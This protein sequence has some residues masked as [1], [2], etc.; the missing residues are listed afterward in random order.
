MTSSAG[1]VTTRYAESL[2]GDL[3]ASITTD[4]A[5]TL[6]LATLHGD[7]VTTIDILPTAAATDPA[8]GITGWSDYT[9]YGAPRDP[10]ATDVVD[11]DTGYGWLGAKQRS[12]TTD[13]AGLTLMGDRLYN[14]VTGR[15]TS[16][17]PEPGGNPN[18]YTYPGDPINMYDLDGHF[19]WGWVKTAVQWGLGNSRGARIFRSACGWTPGWLG[20]ACGGYL[21]GS[22]ASRQN[23]GQAGMWA[24]SAA[25]SFTGAKLVSRFYSSRHAFGTLAKVS[26]NIGRHGRTRWYQRRISSVSSHFTRKHL[27]YRAVSYYSSNLHGAAASTAVSS[28]GRRAGFWD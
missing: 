25:T 6:P 23:H 17:D 11:G 4:G 9:E 12:T 3:A 15:F 13:T 21:A 22:Y 5:V 10:T 20:T 19:G 27:G 18:A 1:A 2:A 8:G 24:I 7:V 16:T 14:P 28:W 26:R